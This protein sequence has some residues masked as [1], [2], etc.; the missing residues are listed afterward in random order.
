MKT[1]FTHGARS[2]RSPSLRRSR[3]PQDL[4]RY[5]AVARPRPARGYLLASTEC[6]LVHPIGM[7]VTPTAPRKGIIRLVSWLLA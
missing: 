5:Q 2:P 4:I 3:D 7:G 6:T 1:S